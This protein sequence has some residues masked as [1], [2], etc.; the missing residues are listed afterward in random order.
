[1]CPFRHVPP[2]L[3][4]SII[5]KFDFGPQVIDLL[6]PLNPVPQGLTTG[7]FIL[8]FYS[9]LLVDSILFLRLLAVYP[10]NITPFRTRLTILGIPILI[11]I[12]RVVS[13][14]LSTE[15]WISATHTLGSTITAGHVV[16]GESPYSK[17]TWIL[18]LV[19]NT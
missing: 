4:S 14:S 19:D 5:T 15:K 8:C 2:E 10:A 6:Y 16:W 13:L 18:Q 9:P 12:A 11:K 3:S 7:W 17:I 1:M